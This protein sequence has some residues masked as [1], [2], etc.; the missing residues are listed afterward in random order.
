MDIAKLVLEYIRV[1]VWVI[2]LTALLRYREVISRLIPASKLKL[3]LSEFG[4]EVSV[5]VELDARTGNYGI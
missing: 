4:I 2:A 3:I 5:P 1:L